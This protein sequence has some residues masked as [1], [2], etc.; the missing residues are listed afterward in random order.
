MFILWAWD[1][2]LGTSRQL[3]ITRTMFVKAASVSINSAEFINYQVCLDKRKNSLTV[4]RETKQKLGF[5]DLCEMGRGTWDLHQGFKRKKNKFT[6]HHLENILANYF[7]VHPCQSLSYTCAWMPWLSYRFQ[8]LW[9][10]QLLL[11]LDFHF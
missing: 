4:L 2:M 11:Y 7:H 1:Q 9:L 3:I 10:L 6:L 5:E 8:I